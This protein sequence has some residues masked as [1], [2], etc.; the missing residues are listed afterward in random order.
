MR[1]GRFDLGYPQMLLIGMVLVTL[2]ALVVAASTSTAAFGIFN[3]GWDGA[4]ELT[5]LAEEAET[6]PMIVR[7]VS[8]YRTADPNGTVALVLSPA[9]A[10]R[11]GEVRAMRSFVVAG[12]TLVVAEDFGPH[13]NLI[14]DQLGADARVDGRLLLDER[15]Y[16]RA[17]SLLTAGNVTNHPLTAGVEQLTFNHGTAVV[18][19]D[20]SV[21]IRTSP[22]AYLDTNR[23]N[24]LDQDEALGS[25]PVVTVE[26]IE[27]G[28]LVVVGDPSIVINAM[29]ERPG[30]RAFVHNVLASHDRVMLDY[31]HARTLPPLAVALLVINEEPAIQLVLGLGGLLVLGW[32]AMDPA[33][34]DRLPGIRPS[35]VDRD[36]PAVT[37][38]DVARDL[39]ERNP[40]IDRER[41]ERVAK[42]LMANRDDGED[43]G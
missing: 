25:Y 12:G 23:N 1:I 13:S 20:A 5:T 11:D 26:S 19:G 34:I 41:A 22:F 9:E 7:N 24:Q 10:Y 8:A 3:P 6:E 27:Q 37:P 30:N 36:S 15:S 42:G 16:Y 35:A 17:P 43:D 29:I 2:T 14:L 38:G 39:D 33:V 40:T 21:L 18:P 31:S 28:R 32:I 4:A